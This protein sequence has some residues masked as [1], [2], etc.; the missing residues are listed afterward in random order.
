MTANPIRAGAKITELAILASAA[1]SSKRDGKRPGY[2]AMKHTRY[3]DQRPIKSL[4]RLMTPTPTE[5]R[6]GQLLP[7]ID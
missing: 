5:M 7:L 6:R 4:H 1:L 2:G 3:R